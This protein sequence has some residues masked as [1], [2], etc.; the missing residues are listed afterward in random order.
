[1]KLSFPTRER[2]KGKLIYIVIGGT[3][4]QNNDEPEIGSQKCQ[5]GASWSFYGKKSN[6]EDWNFLK[7]NFGS[8]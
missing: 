4:C 3:A 8:K 2:K 7:F 1:M 6:F 5:P